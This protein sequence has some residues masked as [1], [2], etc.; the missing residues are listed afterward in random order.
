MTSVQEGVTDPDL[1]VFADAAN[2]AA[3][4]PAIPAMAAVWGP[5]GKAYSA[6]VAGEDPTS[7]IDV[8]RQDHHGGDRE[9]G[10]S[11]SDRTGDVTASPVR[12]TRTTQ[13]DPSRPAPPSDHGTEEQAREQCGHQAGHGIRAG[14]SRRQAA[15]RQPDDTGLFATKGRDGVGAL[16]VKVI[17]LGTVIAVAA[18]LTPTLVGQEKWG[19]LVAIWA[20]AVVLVGTYATHR[21]LPAK[22]LVPGHADAGAVRGLSDRDDRAGVVHERR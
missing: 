4:M 5:L 8:G 16:L 22:Y 20:I 14:R 19:F 10:A 2:A 15:R 1:A 6:I 7:S 12:S 9:A 21:A 13:H 11:P 17:C 18:A 3:P